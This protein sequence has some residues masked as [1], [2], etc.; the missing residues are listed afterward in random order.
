MLIL[1]Y[2]DFMR[3]R[4]YL[5][6]LWEEARGGVIAG[7]VMLVIGF[8]AGLLF[9]KDVWIALEHCMMTGIPLWITNLVGITA[10]A[11]TIFC[12]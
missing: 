4:Y 5:S 11:A 7:V 1:Y 3:I 6:D 12:L 10:V 9:R 8:I 2:M